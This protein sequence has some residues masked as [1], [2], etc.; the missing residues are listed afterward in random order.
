VIAPHA[1]WHRTRNLHRCPAPPTQPTGIQRQH[2]ASAP[3]P[4]AAPLARRS[5]CPGRPPPAAPPACRP[6]PWA[7][8]RARCAAPLRRRQARRWRWRRRCSR[9][10]AGLWPGRRLGLA[11]ARPCPLCAAA[12][13]CR[14]GAGAGR[15]RRHVGAARTTC[16]GPHQQQAACRPRPAAAR[17]R[18]CGHPGCSTGCRPAATTR[19]PVR[20]A[21]APAPPAALAPVARP[22]R[23]AVALKGLEGGRQRAR[24]HAQ[25]AP[26]P[27][28]RRQPRQAEVV[29]RDLAQP[30][31][32]AGRGAAARAGKGR[33]G[34]GGGQVVGPRSLGPHT[35]AAPRHRCRDKAR[36]AAARQA[37]AGQPLPSTR[38]PQAAPPPTCPPAR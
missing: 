33:S 37:P 13:A 26:Q 2:P 9:R 20:T 31:H 3:H 17:Q 16:T 19:T 7:R 22:P 34:G 18:G 23:R 10:R 38:Q 11:P 8:P 30:R 6:A 14:A 4:P 24:R 12:R 25:V 36:V 29:D 15:Q 21:P 32:G 5:R 27:A 1:R 35:A 28:Q